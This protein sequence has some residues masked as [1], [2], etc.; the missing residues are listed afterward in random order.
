[1]RCSLNES[2]MED[3]Q[4]E[5]FSQGNESN[6]NKNIQDD[7]KKE[8]LNYFFNSEENNKQ[9]NNKN[10]KNNKNNNN[11]KNNKNNKNNNNNK[12]NKN[13]KN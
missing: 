1:M 3:I 8:R 4:N 9:Q 7:L 5:L 11:N 6:Q 2:E 10:N 12:N 13:N